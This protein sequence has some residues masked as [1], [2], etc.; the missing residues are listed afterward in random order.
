M[1]AS[2]IAGGHEGPALRGE[3]LRLVALLLGA[4]GRSPAWRPAWL[5]PSAIGLSEKMGFR[6]C[7]F[8]VKICVFSLGF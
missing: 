5:T 3:V 7:V 8:A 6:I 4:L 1:D 2:S